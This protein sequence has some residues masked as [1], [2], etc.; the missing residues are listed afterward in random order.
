MSAKSQFSLVYGSGSGVY[1]CLVSCH[2]CLHS[3][4]LAW[5]A[6]VH[7]LVVVMLGLHRR[8][9]RYPCRS[10]GMAWGATITIQGVPIVLGNKFQDEVVAARAHDMAALLLSPTRSTKRLNFAAWTYATELMK[11]KFE[12]H[13]RHLPAP[14]HADQ[15]LKVNW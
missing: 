11:Y 5:Y 7:R 13:V 1:L 6:V 4:G 8:Y 15:S 2:I 10:I 12:P 14:N 3:P 9:V